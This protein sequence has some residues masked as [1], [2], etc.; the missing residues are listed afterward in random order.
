MLDR[1]GDGV[2][3]RHAV[4]VAS[5]PTGRDAADDLGAGAVVKALS[6]EVDRLAAGDALDDEGGLGVDQDGHGYPATGVDGP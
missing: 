6:R 1:L 3:Y 5:E 2:E 4:D